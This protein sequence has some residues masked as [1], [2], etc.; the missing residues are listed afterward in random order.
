M[1]FSGCYRR[2]LKVRKSIVEI[3]S[4]PARD[5]AKSGR[6][7]DDCSQMGDNH[8]FEVTLLPTRIHI[9]CIIILGALLPPFVWSSS[10]LDCRSKTAYV[11]A[12]LKSEYYEQIPNETIEFAKS[13]AME[14]CLSNNVEPQKVLTA[15]TE[16]KAVKSQLQKKSFLG[17]MFG[18]SERKKGNERLLNRR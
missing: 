1:H 16:K 2:Q 8:R 7:F 14:M 12:K 10:Q 4:T 6:L 17:I 9:H 18:D 13:A 15:T 3:G 5:I 11:V